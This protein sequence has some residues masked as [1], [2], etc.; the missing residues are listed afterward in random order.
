MWWRQRNAFVFKVLVVLAVALRAGLSA[1]SP[2]ASPAACVAGFPLLSLTGISRKGS[3]GAKTQSLAFFCNSIIFLTSSSSNS[4]LRLGPLLLGSFLST[5]GSFQVFS[6]INPGVNP[7]QQ[8][9]KTT[10]VAP[11]SAVS[12]TCQPS[13]NALRTSNRSFFTRKILKNVFSLIKRIDFTQT[14]RR[15]SPLPEPLGFPTPCVFAP[16]RSLRETKQCAF[17]RNKA[18]RCGVQ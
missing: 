17:A 10:S 11:G 4:S 3:K 1:A 18:V 2:P 7:H 14:R 5:K 15:N 16:S 8:P 12:A 6:P 13:A 9:G